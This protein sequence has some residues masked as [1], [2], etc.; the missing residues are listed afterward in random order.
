VK[1]L[2]LVLIGQEDRTFIGRGKVPADVAATL[3]QYP[4]LG[5]KTADA[6]PRATLMGIS[7]VGHIP[8]LEAPDTFHNLL[9]AFL[10]QKP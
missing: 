4:Q 7:G 3:G 10:S 8:H 6:I 9:R 1:P 2:T 5:K